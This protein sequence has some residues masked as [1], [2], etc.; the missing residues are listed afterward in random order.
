MPTAAAPAQSEG[1]S[2]NMTEQE[3]IDDLANFTTSQRW[4]IG[5][6][7]SARRHR[8]YEDAENAAALKRS[9]S[10]LNAPLWKVWRES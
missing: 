3:K 4:A 9:T 5:Q 8:E 7:V 1:T 10:S 2:M 6:A